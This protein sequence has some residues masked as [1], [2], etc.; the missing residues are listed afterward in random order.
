MTTG[1]I[2]N[3]KVKEMA[4]GPERGSGQKSDG[5]K[6]EHESYKK[7][8]AESVVHRNVYIFT[9]LRIGIDKA[10]HSRGLWGSYR[11]NWT[12]VWIWPVHG[13]LDGPILI[14]KTLGRKVALITFVHRRQVLM[15]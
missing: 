3:K 12:G 4:E 5:L 14:I 9:P 7:S 2:S 11:Q 6:A 15:C 13:K 1:G 8:I 10:D